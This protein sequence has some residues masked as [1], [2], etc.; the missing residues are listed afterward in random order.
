MSL[1]VIQLVEWIQFY[2]Y[3]GDEGLYDGL[4]GEYRGEVG[5]KL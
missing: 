1:F 5:L 2:L 3:D 4:V